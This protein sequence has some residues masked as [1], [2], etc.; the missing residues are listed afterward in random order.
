M[1]IKENNNIYKY[2]K[3]RRK[4]TIYTSIFLIIFY[5]ILS[6]ILYYVYLTQGRDFKGNIPFILLINLFLIMMG[7]VGY[8]Y[9]KKFK[10]IQF[11]DRF[12]IISLFKKRV[13]YFKDIINYS[14]RFIIGDETIK[15]H[16]K[17]RK[18]ITIGSWLENYEELSRSIKNNFMFDKKFEYP[19]AKIVWLTFVIIFVIL[20]FYI[21][22]QFPISEILIDWWIMHSL[23]LIL[24]YYFWK[25]SR[26]ITVIDNEARL[27]RPFLRDLILNLREVGEKGKVILE[28]ERRFIWDIWVCT[29]TLDNKRIVFDKLIDNG[30]EL[31]KIIAEKTGFSFLS[32]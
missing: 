23:F 3:N 27:H 24:L 32:A 20:Y 12:E 18:I 28:Y 1:I 22:P 19:V 16:L 26:S 7:L 13:I 11:V 5:Q 30:E 15:L 6:V 10:I 9:D 8:N 14:S 25:S 31:L 4:I 29:I 17:D 2:S 21:G